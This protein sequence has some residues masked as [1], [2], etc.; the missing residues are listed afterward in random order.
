MASIRAHAATWFI[1]HRLKPR[2]SRASDVVEM[3]RLLTPP[4]MRVPRSIRISAGMVGGV[5]GEWVE[6]PAAQATLLYLHGGG[7]FACS[8]E[9]HRP[10]TVAYAQQGFRVFAPNYRLAPEHRFPAAL[11]DALSVCRALLD[12]GAIAISGESAGGGLTLATLLLLRSEGRTMP[13]AAAVFSPW[14]DLA[15]TG[16]SIGTNDRRC[17]MFFGADIGKA[18]LHYAGTGDPRNP[19][20]SPLYGNLA[21]LPPL[22]I[23]VGKDEVLLDDS[24]RFAER[25]R[26]AGVP[27]ELKIWPV[28]PHAWQLTYPVVPEAR[29]SL[30]QAGEFL[31]AAIESARRKGSTA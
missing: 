30:K 12:E 4:S 17:A 19:L 14:T 10:I 8:A 18:A 25:A 26:R 29:Q 9:T 20:V 5:A 7:Y 22:L 1:K 2:L 27:V 11:E 13:A 6:G 16:A 28:V 23:H 15:A 21:G 31:K 24:T 3:R